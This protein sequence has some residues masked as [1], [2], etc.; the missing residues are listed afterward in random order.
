MHADPSGILDVPSAS[1]CELN[2]LRHLATLTQ[3]DTWTGSTAGVSAPKITASIQVSHGP[4]HASFSIIMPARRVC[5]VFATY[6][7]RLVQRPTVKPRNCNCP[8]PGIRIFGC[9]A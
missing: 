7:A 3:S 2:D 8:G 4:F 1:P 6:C 5:T 9:E